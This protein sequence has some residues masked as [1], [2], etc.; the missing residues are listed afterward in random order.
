MIYSHLN[1]KLGQIH[2][3]FNIYTILEAVQDSAVM[4]LITGVC[5]INRNYLNGKFDYLIQ[6][7]KTLLY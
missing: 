6:T 7:S 2:H 5:K 3:L 1:K 4:D